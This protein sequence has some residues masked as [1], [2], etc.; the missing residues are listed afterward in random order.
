[1]E[2][3][4]IVAPIQKSQYHKSFYREIRNGI[5]KATGSD[6]DA[7]YYKK[8]I[9]MP[10]FYNPIYYLS[11]IYDFYSNYEELFIYYTIIQLKKFNPKNII[12]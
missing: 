11:S 12:A 4:M 7:F 2:Q 9:I 3:D 6:F 10:E 5:S 8:P 1:M